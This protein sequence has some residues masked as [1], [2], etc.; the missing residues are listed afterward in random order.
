MAPY[1]SQQNGVVERQFA[2]DLRR[3]QSM[4]EVADLTEGLRNLLRNEAT[5]IMTATTLENISCNDRQSHLTLYQKS[6][7]KSPFLKL[8]H[9]VQ[10]VD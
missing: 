1:T 8:E 3:A 9:L 10:L 6:N 5:S 2:P 7:N 4:M